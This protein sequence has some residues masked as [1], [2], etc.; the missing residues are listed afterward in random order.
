MNGSQLRQLII[1]AA[2]TYADRHNLPHYF[3]LSKTA[4]AALFLPD[5]DRCLH[6]NFLDDSY[7]AI[8]ESLEWAQRL[9]K[10]HSRSKALPLERREEAKEL[11]S[12]TSSD[13]LL[14]NVFCYPGVFRHTPLVRLLELSAPA[15]PDL[16]FGF[17]PRV[18][19]QGT[20]R[21]TEVDLMVEDLLIEAKLTEPGFT[22]KHSD[23]VKR[24]CDFQ[25]VFYPACLPVSDGYYL[26]YQLLRNVLAA[27]HLGF[28]FRLIC[29]ARRD[30]LIDAVCRGLRAVRESDLRTRCDVVTWQEVASSVP[31]PLQAFLRDKYGIAP[32]GSDDS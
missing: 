21:D 25:S 24:Y 17:N 31:G 3:S 19:R 10:R 11:D 14:M 1:E 28:R 9:Q 23:A 26:H 13:A 5:Q 30:D 32:S 27:H 2:K 20:G 16:V 18:P 15:E 4:P 6:G 29:D 12:C 22:R 7:R 8:C